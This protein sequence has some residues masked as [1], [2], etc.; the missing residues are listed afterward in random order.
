MGSGWMMGKWKPMK[1]EQEAN[2]AAPVTKPCCSDL[3]HK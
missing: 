3:A 2:Y 1:R